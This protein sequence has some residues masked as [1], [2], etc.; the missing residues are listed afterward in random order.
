M[1]VIF[2]L[3]GGGDINF[4]GGGDVAIF[5]LLFGGA[6]LSGYFLGSGSVM[7]ALLPEMALWEIHSGAKMVPFLL[8]F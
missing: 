6:E 1:L 5:L 2:F 4:S 8:C 3:G 7:E